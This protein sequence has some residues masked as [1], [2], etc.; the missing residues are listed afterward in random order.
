MGKAG[1][2]LRSIGR[3]NNFN[4]NDCYM[5]Y[6]VKFRS[7]GKNVPAK[8][9]KL[10]NEALKAEIKAIS[11][12][13]IIALGKV[14]LA[15][16][17]Y[18]NEKMSAAEYRGILVDYPE[19]NNIKIFPTFS[20]GHILMSPVNMHE[21]NRDWRLLSMLQRNGK[22]EYSSTQINVVNDPIVLQGIVR[23]TLEGD[24]LILL[25]LDMEWEGKHWQDP[26]GYVRTLQFTTKV[27][28]AYVV[29]FYDENKT[30]MID[31]EAAWEILRGFL[32]D[33][34]VGIVGHN[35]ISDGQ[36]LISYGIDIR[37]KT[38]YD[39]MLAEHTI[40]PLGPFGLEALTVKYTDL[41][42]YDQA[43]MDWK[44]DGGDTEHGYGKVPRDILNPYGGT[45]VDAPLRIM[46]AQMEALE[47]YT[48]PRGEYPSL[49]DMVMPTQQMLYEIEMTGMR[50]DRQRLTELTQQFQGKLVEME[51]Q[52]KAMAASPDIGMPEFNFNST[53]Q[54]QEVIFNKLGI[55]PVKTTDGK[56]WEWVLD[57][58]DDVAE[59]TN[60]STDKATLEILQD[61]HPFI[62]LMR[63]TRKIEHICRTW[64]RDDF[65]TGKYDE[66][67]KGGGIISKIW[68]DGKIHSHFSQLKETGRFGSSKPNCFPGD[69][70][71]LTQDGW[72]RFDNLPKD[73]KLA[74]YDQETKE[75]SF[76]MPEAYIEKP[77]DGD[78]IHIKSERNIDIVCTED[79]RLL[80][81]NKVSGNKILTAS[82]LIS[83]YLGANQLYHAGIYKS[84]TLH[85]TSDQIILIC[86]LQAD[87]SINPSGGI[88]W[89]IAKNR[90]GERLLNSLNQ[91][92]I[93]YHR[94]NCKDHK[95]YRVYV[96]KKDI[97]LWLLDKKYFNR[98]ILQLDYESLILFVDE[99][100]NWDGCYTRKSMYS[101]NVK[102]N[103]E[104]VQL[105]CLLV[106]RRA[107]LRSY[108][109][110]KNINWQVDVVDRDKSWMTNSIVSRVRYNGTVYCVT[111]PKGTIIVRSAG[112]VIP[113]ISA[114]CQNWP[115]RAEGDIAKIFAGLNPSEEDK[116]KIPPSIKTVIVPDDKCIFI[117][118]DW[119]Q[120]ELF[121]LANL[122][123]DANMISALTTPGKDLHDITTLRSFNVKVLYPDGNE[124]VEN[125]LLQLAARDIDGFKKLQKT[126]L[127]VDQRGKIMTRDDFKNTI[128]VSGKNIG[129]IQCRYKIAEKSG[130]AEML[131][132]PEGIRQGQS[133]LGEINQHEAATSIKM[134]RYAE[135][136]QRTSV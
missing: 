130:K 49:W 125:D 84:G 18:G 99:L 103:A 63:N 117:E 48:K 38:V 122:S 16:L 115:K 28:M 59:E 101:S 64:L 80:V 26:E 77:Y 2:L 113:Y 112:S 104:W 69:V 11:P 128:R 85:Y 118:A 100:W 20:L 29:E 95:K 36:W 60:P 7:R 75:I 114:Q 47:P 134:K 67:T 96:S 120:A 108:Q 4:L 25:S 15:A 89:G 74:Q 54:V 35:V 41:G 78:M 30:P 22:I 116:R 123:K 58:D 50:V 27:G 10:C 107:R 92:K 88:D 5:T 51:S 127:Y 52:L 81:D 90:K 72:V 1:E 40:N 42:R 33:P 106:G 56:P 136:T 61:A 131:I 68:P 129:V 65:D 14:A 124:V 21:C 57:Q 86:A 87:G 6:A 3:E 9:I 73:V 121:V 79:H 71:I 93:P 53:D 31:V 132:R 76:V 23:D 94:H 43:L 17:L 39:T 46:Y 44:R 109:G 111:M 126:L 8:D 70:E 91:L 13:Y 45:D 105:A 62:G 19:D 66:T 102:T 12:S 82:Q 110:T 55:P 119:K 133:I 34:R 97:P 83:Q 37:E 24:S 98:W 135:H 32:A